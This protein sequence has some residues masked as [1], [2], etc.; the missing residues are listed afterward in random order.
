[1][2]SRSLEE[3]AA[4]HLLCKLAMYRNKRICT[5]CAHL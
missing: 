3:D 5:H 2:K 4:N 1:M